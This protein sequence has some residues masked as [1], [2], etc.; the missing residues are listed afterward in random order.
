MSY[1]N[2]NDINDMDEI[3]FTKRFPNL[4]EEDLRK[5]KEAV[6]GSSPDVTTYVG[7]IR[8]LSLSAHE[9]FKTTGEV[10]LAQDSPSVTSTKALKRFGKLSKVLE[11]I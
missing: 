5:V 10:R 9:T 2:S 8:N 1:Y 11:S 7:T 3:T 4:T 6:E